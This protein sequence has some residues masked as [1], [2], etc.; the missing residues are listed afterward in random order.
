M[1]TTLVQKNGGINVETLEETDQ[2]FS[3]TGNGENPDLVCFSHLR[4]NFV[5]QRPQHLM[6]RFAKICRTFF[7]EEPIFGEHEQRY[8]IRHEED[9]L[10]VIV[11][12]LPNGLNETEVNSRL[13]ALVSEV[14][15]DQNINRYVFWYYTPMS[16]NYTREFDPEVVVYDCMDELSAFK[17]APESLKQLE[18]ELLE[19]AQIVFT[20]GQSLYE[21]K[22]KFHHN[23]FPFPSS[24]DRR[25][26]QAARYINE[27]QADQEHVPHPRFGFYGVV[28]ERFDIELLRDVSSKRPDW[29][30]VIIGPVVKIDPETLPQGPNIHYLGMKTYE[31][32]PLY[33]SHWDVA[34]VLFARNESTRFISPTKTPEYLAAG[35]P[36]ISTSIKDVVDLYGSEK[37]VHIADTADEFIA[38]AIKIFEESDHS[39]WLEDVDVFLAGNSWDKTWTSMLHLINMID[40]DKTITENPKKEAHV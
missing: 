23:I 21:F 2:I 36:V 29:H 1:K 13:T 9:K 12:H 4:W 8:D 5:Y 27:D 14:L 40:K 32:L 28:D 38:A 20:G 24:I 31:Q 30:F 33:I 10:W 22:K 15:R 17:F 34:M 26:F 11:P 6:S 7:I 39:A 25:H 18:K 35:R 19:K 3:L 16:L 37:M